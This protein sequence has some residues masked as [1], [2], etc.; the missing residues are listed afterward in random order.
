MNR[1]LFV[2]DEPG[3]LE[4]LRDVFRA[5]RARWETVFVQTPEQAL[6]E[7]AREPFQLLVTDLRMPSMDGLALL[8]QV[9]ARHPDV[10]RIVLSGQADLLLASRASA[11]AHR[12]LVKPCSAAVI[13]THVGRALELRALVGGDGL[14][15][16]IGELGTVPSTP[17]LYADLTA[18]LEAPEAD[19]DRLAQ[20]VRKD[21]GLAARVLQ[22]ANSAYCGLSSGVSSIESAILRL[23]F[24]TLR[25]VALTMEVFADRDEPPGGRGA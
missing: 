22:F 5:E 17:A 12:Y 2:D 25:H 19:L 4:G 1:I 8:G 7:L 21:V 20:A 24:N 9:R 16:A 3:I 23:G 11:L 15:A 13:R 18:A 6:V 14:R 10:T